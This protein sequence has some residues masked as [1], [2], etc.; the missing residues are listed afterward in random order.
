MET[1][2][3]DLMNKVILRYRHESADFGTENE[4]VPYSASI[5]EGEGS[6]KYIDDM[7]NEGKDLDSFLEYIRR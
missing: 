1:P 5:G 3:E 4:S 6:Y 7:V 2:L